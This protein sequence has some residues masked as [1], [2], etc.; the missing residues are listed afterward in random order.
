VIILLIVFLFLLFLACAVVVVCR[1]QKAEQE[2]EHLERQKQEIRNKL[3]K[4]R[5]YLAVFDE[6]LALVSQHASDYHNSLESGTSEA[7]MKMHRM[8]EAHKNLCASLEKNLGHALAD[9]LIELDIIAS[10]LSDYAR[11]QTGESAEDIDTAA[12]QKLYDTKSISLTWEKEFDEYLQLV[13]KAVHQAA[14]SYRES[15]GIPS[16]QSRRGTSTDLRR[17]GVT[18]LTELEED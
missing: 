7:M 5:S 8:I 12:L 13:G 3:T 15:L 14:V 4:Y 1:L 9:D 2:A 11:K 10:A 17:A 16:G 6:R 18:G